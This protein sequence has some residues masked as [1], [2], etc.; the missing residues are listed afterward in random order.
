MAD[1]FELRPL[2]QF[3]LKSLI[4]FRIG[5]YDLSFTNSTLF[6]FLG[7]ICLS[8]LLML[9]IKKPQLVPNR[10]Q[11]MGELIHDFVLGTVNENTLGKG[12]QYFPFIF[13]LFCFILTLNL[14]G[15]LPH[16]FTVT[17][18]ISV[19][20]AF[21]L[22][23]FVVLNIIAFARHGLKFFHHFLPEGIPLF[24]APV[25]IVIELFVYLI[26]PVTLSIR[27]AANM[28]AGHILLY[29]AATFVVIGGITIGIIPISFVIVFTGIEIFVAV[30][31]AYIFTILT[32]T[33]LNDA[34]H[35]H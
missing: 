31:Q 13:S 35:L 14:L 1:Q 33:Y 21:A 24:L 4:D 22:I 34:I 6:M 15:L 20:L 12:E 23:V 17:S 32:C 2:D 8:G 26:R 7:L 3:N 11:A 10:M 25:M 27:L 28:M 5:E 18:H 19:T 9:F 16:G 30:L 29:I